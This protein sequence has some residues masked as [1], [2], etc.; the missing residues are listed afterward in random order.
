M[1]GSTWR[2]DPERGDE[3]HINLE[4][5]REY[6]RVRE[7]PPQAPPIM[8][9]FYSRKPH[10]AKHGYTPQCKGCL[11]M[12]LEKAQQGR[13]DSCHARIMELLEQRPGTRMR[14]DR[15]E[16]MRAAKIARYL[17]QQEAAR[18]RS[19]T[20]MPVGLVGQPTADPTSAG[21]ADTCLCSRRQEAGGRSRHVRP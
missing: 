10:I 15:P 20:V 5:A 2:P 13:S 18:S 4:V 9:S 14:V 3:A 17:E 11:A 7:D 19:T 6:P 12:R 16:D 8:R 1:R 21:L